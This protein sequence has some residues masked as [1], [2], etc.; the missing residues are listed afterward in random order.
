MA[1]PR[2][3]LQSRL[4]CDIDKVLKQLQ[5]STNGGQ[6]F[7]S[8]PDA[9]DAIQRSN[10]SLKRLKKR[11]L[12]DAIH[13]VLLLH[14]QEADDSSDSEAAL[15]KAEEAMTGQGN[16]GFLLNRQMT[17]L[18]HRD[19]AKTPNLAE[20]EEK[21]PTKKR[22]L[23]EESEDAVLETTKAQTNGNT[24]TAEAALSTQQE[25]PPKKIQKRSRFTI[26][27][28]DGK[29]PLGGLEPFSAELLRLTWQTLKLPGY[30]ESHDSKRPAGIIISG[31]RGMGKRTLVKNIACEL[32]VPLVCLDMCFF[33]TE[34]M[35]KNM[36]EA[37]DAAMAQP[38]SI[39]FIG[40]V[41]HYMGR[42]GS[43][44]HNDS[45][46]K[47]TK[48]F[49]LQMQRLQRSRGG[50]SNHFA[51]ATT[52]NIDEVD[53]YILQQGLFE[54]TLKPEIPDYDARKDVLKTVLGNMTLGDDV[55][56]DEVA[57]ITHGFVPAE[58]AFVTE[59]AKRFAIHTFSNEDDV[60]LGETELEDAIRAR[61]L[62]VLRPL[63]YNMRPRAPVSMDNFKTALKGFVPALRKEGFTA[64]PNV[65]WD[66]VG[67]LEVARKRLQ[68]SIIGPI[69]HP[70]LYGEFGLSQS[71]GVLLW[72]P[73]GCGKTLI[74]QAVANDAK[75]SFILINGPELLNKY[76]GESERAVRELFERARSSKPCILFF[77]E[78]DSVVPPRANASTESGARLV[79]A[80][81]TELDG[82]KDRSGV[83]VIGTTNRPELID[84]AILR[85]GRLGDQ[86]FIDLPTPSERIDILQAIYRTRQKNPTPDD[87]EVLA[88]VA[89]DTRCT[90]FSGADLSELQT[91]AAHSA[92]ERFLQDEDLPKGITSADWEFALENTRPSVKDPESYRRRNVV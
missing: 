82:V 52:S 59:E 20:S 4:E 80:L 40:E 2:T 89:L 8:T 9:Y 3:I 88:N 28:V 30:D 71:A 72:G 58:I 36:T 7:K 70:A 69:K 68:T 27:H 5:S 37:F 74:A 24:S 6:R 42:P 34:R 38:H 25:Q 84:E 65:T 50:D 76:V 91:K 21:S 18:W 85:P 81:L 45:H 11:P 44:H 77:D 14:R 53:P 64:I 66:Q 41:H 22:R 31:P 73:P 78:V 87:L 19:T 33:D 10:S 57:R 62:E 90:N 12:E 26:E 39:I 56:L 60:E 83:Y 47:A 79:N 67:A 1:R 51:I 54:K 13:R 92:L 55:D 49:T 29:I 43:S 63:R 23:Q 15:E 16:G 86:I 48:L 75:A 46:A 17:K 32:E 61:D 35:E